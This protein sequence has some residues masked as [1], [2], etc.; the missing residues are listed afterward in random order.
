MKAKHKAKAVLGKVQG[1]LLDAKSLY[2]RLVFEL[3]SGGA[4]L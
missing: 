4:C 2:K 3:G 1:K